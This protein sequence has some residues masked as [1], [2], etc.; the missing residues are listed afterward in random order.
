M[1]ANPEANTA[2]SGASPA[3]KPGLPRIAPSHPIGAAIDKYVHRVRDIR[4]TARVYIPRALQSQL[5]VAEKVRADLLDALSRLESPDAPTRAAAQ[6]DTQ[7]GMRHVRRMSNS[8]PETVLA[9]GL[10]LGM[11]SA[12]DA[13]TGELL[14]ALFTLRPEL[15]AAL[16]D[17][18]ISLGAIL[19]A[20]DLA[21]LKTTVLTGEIENFRRKSYAEQFSDLEKRFDITLTAFEAW[22]RFIECA[23]RRNLLTHC[24]GAVSHQYIDQ[25]VAAGCKKSDL[26]ELGTVVDLQGGYFFEACELLIEVGAK[27]GQTLW[28][29]VLPSEI[30]RAD[31]TL[32]DLLFDALWVENW[33]RARTLG[34]FACSQKKL[35]SERFR[36]VFTINYAQALK[37]GGLESDVAKLLGGFDWSASAPEFQ[38]GVAVLTDQFD[39]AAKL[40]RRMGT[41]GEISEADYHTWPLFRIFTTTPTFAAA[42]QDVFGY[43]FARKLEESATKA[44]A[45]AEKT[46]TRAADREAELQGAAEST[47]PNT[48][49]GEMST[50][51]RGDRSA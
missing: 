51:A 2:K 6:S 16:G 11:F 36:S 32:N 24:D 4:L 13:F 10:F 23:Q 30:D 45:E 29:K 47:G 44:V 28:R 25:C 1:A 17:R 37:W 46:L 21:S 5:K 38:L 8:E 40:V 18:S 14:S 27:L 35:S 33:K 9:R 12:F 3:R 41:A 43:P 19:A 20:S 15:Y 34:Q 31:A 7:R 22:P 39:Q 50:D 48:G 42:Y 26:P 49:P